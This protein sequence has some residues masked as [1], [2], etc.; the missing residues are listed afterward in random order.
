MAISIRNKDT[1]RLAREVARETGE[2]ITQAILHSLEERLL[3]LTDRRHARDLG[4]EI[5][6]IG[7]RCAA[8][9]DLDT[10]SAEEILGYDAHGGDDFSQ[11]DVTAVPY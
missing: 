5:R 9:P 6:K 2:S 11:T 1:E 8:L 4:A 10:R 3:R 7:E